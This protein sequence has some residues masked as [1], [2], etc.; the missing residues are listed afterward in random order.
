MVRFLRAREDR[1]RKLGFES[2][3]PL[4]P[5]KHGNEIG[6]YSSGKFREIK[7]MIEIPGVMFTLKRFRDTFCQTNIDRDPSLLSDVSVAMG[8]ATTRTTEMHY[9]SLKNEQA[10]DRLQRSWQQASAK[11]RLINDRIEVTG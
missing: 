2:A 8:H 5:A 6:F 9:G 1:L 7:K 10:L 4:V 11:N 3:T